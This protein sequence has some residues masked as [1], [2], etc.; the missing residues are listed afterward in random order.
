MVYTFEVTPGAIGQVTVDIEANVAD[1]RRRQ[2]E[3]GGPAVVV[4]PV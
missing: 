2:R 4:H 1:G 3:Q